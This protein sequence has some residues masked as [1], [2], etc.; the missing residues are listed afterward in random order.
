[1]RKLKILILAVV[2]LT[3]SLLQ[4]SVFAENNTSQVLDVVTRGQGI[5][6]T[7][8]AFN[9][10]MVGQV[11]K[12]KSL[13]SQKLLKNYD[14][15]LDNFILSGGNV[16]IDVTVGEE[17]VQLFGLLHA[18]YKVQNGINSIVGDLT[19]ETGRYSV[20]LFEIFNDNK[21]DNLLINRDLQEKPHLKLYLLDGDKNIILF[22]TDLPEALRGLEVG[23]FAEKE[24]NKKEMFWFKG[25]AEPEMVKE[26]TTTE[27]S[28]A[29][30]S[31]K[32]DLD[33]APMALNSFSTWT[34]PTTY[35]TSFY[36]G[37][38]YTQCWSLPYLS[39]KHVNVTSSD[40]TWI[41]QFKIA[42]HTKVGNYTYYGNNVFEYKNL[43]IAFG[44]GD[45]S[46]MIRTFQQGRIYDNSAFNGGLKKVGDKI[47]TSLI[48]K[49]LSAVPYGSTINDVIGYI[50][51]ATSTS[52]EVTLGSQGV[53]LSGSPVSAA[54]EKLASKF[55]LEESTDHSGR[56]D[57][58]H[59]FTYQVV[60][61]YEGNGSSKNTTGNLQL[62]FDVFNSQTNKT[63]PISKDFTLA[64]R[65]SK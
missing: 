6:L 59:Y 40:S 45:Y 31:G 57:N 8:D 46:T 19:D 35:Y 33:F 47:A 32:T 48:K 41:A 39:Y 60:L 24:D 62:K 64:Y 10:S 20:L 43:K 63:T 3:G 23:S 7:V 11:E 17:Q 58:G 9:E 56:T 49:T 54:G 44:S 14:L 51:T 61:N 18:S 38:D 2:V 37:T 15:K 12:R 21:N 55:K 4:T 52:G 5:S 27:T 36:V 16:S 53:S 1:M 28:I 22:E 42:E 29:E 50:N 30:A 13:E 26:I 34:N 25:L 65:A